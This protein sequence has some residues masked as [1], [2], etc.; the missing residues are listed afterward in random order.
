MSQTELDSSNVRVAITGAWYTGPTG[1]A[2]PESGTSPLDPAMVNLGYVSDDGTERSVDRS[3]N[4]IKA[5]QRAAI[6]RKVITDASVSYKLALIETKK[7]VLE[8]YL[9]VT[10]SEDGIADIDPAQTGGRRSYA[11]DAIDGDEIFRAFIP[12]GE[13]TEVGSLKFASGE[14]RAYEVTITAYGSAALDGKCERLYF[15]SLADV[16]KAS[17]KAS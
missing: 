14:A 10:L 6:V 15:T 5:W 12:E 11:F 3:S 4:D 2:I 16:V 7:P 13:V 1:V 9:G 17:K 8:M